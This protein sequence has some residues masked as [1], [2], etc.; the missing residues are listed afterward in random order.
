MAAMTGHQWRKWRDDLEEEHPA[1]LAD[2]L[3]TTLD[4]HILAHDV[5]NGFDGSA[6]DHRLLALLGACYINILAMKSSQRFRAIS[7]S[8]FSSALFRRM[9]SGYPNA[10]VRLQNRPERIGSRALRFHR[11]AHKKGRSLIKHLVPSLT[12]H[13]FEEGFVRNGRALNNQLGFSVILDRNRAT[14]GAFP[15]AV[16]EPNRYAQAT[17]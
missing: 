14:Q 5:L 13:R 10:G 11:Q 17:S 6:N 16:D 3:G 4:A 7:C 1:Q 15:N 12:F 8:R 9:S 2:A